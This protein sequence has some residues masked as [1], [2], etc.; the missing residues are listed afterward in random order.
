VVG[1][2]VEL[3]DEALVGPQAVDLEATEGDVHRRDRQSPRPAEA[4]EPPLEA[5]TGLAER[6]AA[7]RRRARRA[8]LPR[9]LPAA[10]QQRSRARISVAVGERPLLPAV[11]EAP[12][13]GIIVADG[14]SCKTQIAEL[15]DRRALHTAQVLA[16]ARERGPSE[17]PGLRPENGYPDV[18]PARVR[19]AKAAAAATIAVAAGAALVAA[20]GMARGRG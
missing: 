9:R 10:A 20:A 5:G 18:E 15:T 14:F 7:S 1:P 6:K 8:P 2:A 12:E 13:A 17:P 3:D 19:P 4:K 11:R 16:M